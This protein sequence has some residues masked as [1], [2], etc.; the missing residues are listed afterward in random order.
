MQDLKAVLTCGIMVNVSLACQSI[1]TS[2]K[3]EAIFTVSNMINKLCIE[4]ELQEIETL[5]QQYNIEENLLDVLRN[6][7][8]PPEI[9]QLALLT[10][11][12]LFKLDEEDDDGSNYRQN[13]VQ[14][15]GLDVLRKTLM[16]EGVKEISDKANEM[17]ETYFVVEYEE[18]SER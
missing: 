13:F 1:S 6:V 2:V 12:Y 8:T 4:D 7:Q 10:F 5:L 11:E 14:L 18:D 3:K 16:I 9:Q 15:G 17:N